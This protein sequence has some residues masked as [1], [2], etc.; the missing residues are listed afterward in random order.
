MNKKRLKKV[1]EIYAGTDKAG[2]SLLIFKIE[3]GRE[4]YTETYTR[5]VGLRIL[6]REKS[7]VK[8]GDK[9]KVKNRNE[10]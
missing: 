7:E 8:E 5:E 4:F 10:A 2:K 3:D 6:Q 1:V 9:K